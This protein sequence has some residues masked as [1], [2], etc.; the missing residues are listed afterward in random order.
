LDNIVVHRQLNRHCMF[1][2]SSSLQCNFVIVEATY[3]VYWFGECFFFVGFGCA[4]CCL[5][6]LCKVSVGA[7]CLLLFTSTLQGCCC[8]LVHNSTCASAFHR[9]RVSFHAIVS[10]SI[11]SLLFSVCS[12][13][14]R[15]FAYFYW[16]AR[17]MFLVPSV[18]RLQFRNRW[19]YICC[20][21]V[22]WLLLVRWFVGSS[23]VGCVCLAQVYELW[24]PGAA[25]GPVRAF[26][27]VWCLLFSFVYFGFAGLGSCADSWSCFF[28]FFFFFF[29][30]YYFFWALYGVQ[31][32]C[33]H[34]WTC[35]CVIFPVWRGRYMFC[36][37]VKFCWYFSVDMIENSGIK[38][39]WTTTCAIAISVVF[40]L[41]IKHMQ[42]AL[43]N[44][45]W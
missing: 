18:L 16:H 22:R 29:F 43:I 20:L 12:L 44:H 38:N 5:V 23:V 8:C 4:C 42:N 28:F 35:S 6:Q 15:M 10:F 41:K 39:N 30:Y 33:T 2:T 40:L 1:H 14:V 27:L 24:G 34:E 17:H 45:I 21:L 25:V 11:P 3:I 36:S 7:C 32:P 19:R 31:S 13:Q 26:S 37:A 9:F